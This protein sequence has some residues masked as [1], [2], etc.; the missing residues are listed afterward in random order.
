MLESQS[1]VVTVA[2]QLSVTRILLCHSSAI[3]NKQFPSCGPRWWLQLFSSHL[4]SRQLEKESEQRGGEEHIPS[5]LRALP[6]NWTHCFKLLCCCPILSHMAPCSCRETGK[7][8]LTLSSHMSNWLLW[9]LL[10]LRKRL[11]T[12]TRRHTLKIRVDNI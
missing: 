1:R 12:D 9:T 10:L 2:P 6:R 5:L 4:H 3:F 8:V 7:C 11:R